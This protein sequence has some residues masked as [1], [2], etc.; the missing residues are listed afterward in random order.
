MEQDSLCKSV[1]QSG[2]EPDPEALA[3]A[4]AE[5]IR[6]TADRPDAERPS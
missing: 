5:L 1:F 4:L 2:G 6:R 3:R